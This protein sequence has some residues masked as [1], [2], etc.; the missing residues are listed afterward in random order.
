MDHVSYAWIGFRMF[1]IMLIN[2]KTSKILL[3]QSYRIKAVNKFQEL[4][5][6]YS[7]FLFLIMGLLKAIV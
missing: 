3:G 4:P 1:I 5:T 7:I 2:T 6:C